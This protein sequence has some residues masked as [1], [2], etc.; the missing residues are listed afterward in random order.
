MDWFNS[1]TQDRLLRM[2]HIAATVLVSNRIIAK[3]MSKQCMHR[4]LKLLGLVLGSVEGAVRHPADER[5][6]TRGI[7]WSCTILQV[8][9][10]A[11]AP[12]V[13][14]NASGAPQTLLRGC[15]C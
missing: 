1:T 2:R 15:A 8:D 6:P 10:F 9:T 4:F 11:R 14:A 3:E 5:F 12:P 13:R 7:L